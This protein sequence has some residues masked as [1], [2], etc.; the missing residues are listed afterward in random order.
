ME[1]FEHKDKEFVLYTGMH[2]EPV[3]GYEERH[4]ML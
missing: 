1:N 4:H 2:W 3:E